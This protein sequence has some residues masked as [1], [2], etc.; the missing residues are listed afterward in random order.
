M[1]IYL[2]FLP[3]IMVYIYKKTIGNKEYYYLRASVREKGKIVV[4]DLLY[5]GNNINEIKARLK[6]VPSKY[7]KEIRKAYKTLHKFID[8][9]IY[10]EKSKA[11]KLKKDIFL[12]K[13]SAENIEACRLHWHDK[14]TS[15]DSKTKQ[16]TLKNFVIDF[17]F[18]TTSIEGNTITL[19]EAQNLLAENLTPKNKT[20]REIYDLQNTEIVF[21]D[22][23]NKK[24]KE[25]SHEFICS[26]HDSLLKNI[27]SRQGYRTADVRVFR[28]K[29]DSTPAQY[30]KADMNI[31]LK[32]YD[33]NKSKLPP[34]VLAVIFHHKFEKIHPFM[35]GNGRTG[36]MLLNY[37]LL[38]NKYPPIVIRK[39][40][41][42]EYL[43]Q[44]SK[45]DKCDIAK[46]DS[47]YGGL[48]EF[49]AFEMYDNYWNMF[50]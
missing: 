25:I 40:N 29:F 50:L 28:A 5:L 2:L 26:T 23:F 14:F 46:I 38:K 47:S 4:K 16:E 36:R 19:R 41:R 37:I 32:W 22:I 27:D 1:F 10:L 8:F 31:L 12:S 3:N 30:I 42:A 44:L 21:F 7:S 11:L 9:N 17:A 49:A 24:E 20:L 33:E 15:L 39:K 18:N 48:I 13:E 45:A 6:N 35:D 34:F 43:E